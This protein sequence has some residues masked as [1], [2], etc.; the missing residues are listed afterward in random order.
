[1]TSQWWLLTPQAPDSCISAAMILVSPP[2]TP[3]PQLN[4]SRPENQAVA[5]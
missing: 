4:P 5:R 3:L 2:P 1:M